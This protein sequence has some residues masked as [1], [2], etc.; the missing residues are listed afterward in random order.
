MFKKISYLATLALLLLFLAACGGGG[1]SF[2]GFSDAEKRYLYT[3][4]KS[5]YLWASRVVSSTSLSS[6][7]TP[8]QMI[9]SLRVNPP[10][11][12]SYM[13][14]MKQYSNFANQRTAG[15]GFAY[16]N[17]F[18][19][20]FTRIDA[21]AYSK[22]KRGDRIL[23]INGESISASLIRETSQNLGTPAIFSVERDGSQVDLNIT[24]DYYNFKV[25]LDRIITHNGTKI[26][27]LRYDSFTESSVD[28]FEAA[29]TRFKN[30][31]IN[32]LVIDMRYNGGGSL[33][34]AS[35]L[36]DNITAAHPDERQFYL[37][38]NDNYKQNNY[39][40]TFEESDLQDGN[41]FNLTRVFFLTT[42]NTA[43]ASE[44]VINALVPYLGSDN[45]ILIGSHTHGKPVG[46]HGRRYGDHAYFLINFIIRN[47]YGNSTSFNGIDPTCPAADDINHTMGDENETMFSSAIYYIENGSCP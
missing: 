22:L 34:V 4:F 45:V 7:Q 13:M 6:F 15:F 8:Q 24:P 33:Y 18:T 38:W 27:Y 21:P 36:L 17:D 43:S 26:G 30:A 12:W 23:S 11:R 35:N 16:T 3:L 9:N 20:I 2:Q 1:G 14:T 41:E 40:Y 32:E 47:N 42:P 29:F 25:T 46:M 5:E 44:A 10:D 28:E 19:V 31:G 37:D 39:P